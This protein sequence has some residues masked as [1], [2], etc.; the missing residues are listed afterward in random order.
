MRK[1]GKINVIIIGD[2]LIFRHGLKKLLETEEQL[3]VQNDMEDLSA[4]SAEIKNNNPDVI[5]INSTEVDNSDFE[6]FVANY[7]SDIPVLVLT[8]SEALHVH[9]KYLLLGASGVVTKVQSPEILFKAIKHV[10]MN[11]LWFSRKVVLQTISKL[12]EEK[13]NAP[14]KLQAQK[15]SNLTQREW[16]V[17]NGI[18]SGMKNKAIAEHLFITETTVRH[19]LTSIFEKLNVKSRLAL[20]ILAFNDGIIEVPSESNSS[21]I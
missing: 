21:L 2:Y 3:H 13:K 11:D 7:C 4:A 12:I 20:A 10:N 5:I 9:Q 6:D 18:C 16:D 17:L 19:H 15:Y 8:H 14:E 1:S